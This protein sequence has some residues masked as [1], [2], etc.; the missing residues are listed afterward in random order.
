MNLFSTLLLLFTVI[1][2]IELSILIAIGTQL[3]PINTIIL[4]VIT[5]ITG[6]WLA[7][8]QGISALWNIRNAISEGKMPAEELLDGLMILVAGVF[9]ITPGILTDITGILLLIPQVRVI[10][11]NLIKKRLQDWINRGGGSFHMRVG[12]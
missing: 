9:L 5:A 3:G 11:K 10:V 1:P 2:L 7:R 8:S 6:A 4:V 12:G